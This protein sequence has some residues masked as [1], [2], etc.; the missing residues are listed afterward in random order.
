MCCCGCLNCIAVSFSAILTAHPLP[1]VRP[2][3][4]ELDAAFFTGVQKSND[5]DIHERHSVEVQ[6]NPRPS[7][8]QLRLQFLQVLRLQPT[9]QTNHRLEA[10]G[11]FFKFYCHL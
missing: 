7:A 3:V 8:F 11:F 2:A 4:E 1:Y 6:R 10:A 9:A 5:L